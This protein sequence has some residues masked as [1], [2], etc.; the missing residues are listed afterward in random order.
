MQ[1]KPYFRIYSS[2]SLLSCSLDELIK[3]LLQNG[4]SS[5]VLNYNIN[6]VLVNKQQNRPKQLITTVPKKEVSLVLPYL[7]L[8]S[9]IL[10]KQVKACINK[11]FGW[12]DLRVFFQ[13]H[14]SYK[15]F[16]RYK[17]RLTRSQ[18][19]RFVDKASCWHCQD[20]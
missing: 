19:S 18:M 8:Q 17:D 1:D 10:T 2:P 7:G 6:D 3:L 16:F 14:T 4:Y 13:S 11:F 15:S 20:F 9:R 12:F 5:G